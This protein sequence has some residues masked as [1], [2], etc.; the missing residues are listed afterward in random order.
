[1]D[2]TEENSSEKKKDDESNSPSNGKEDHWAEFIAFLVS[3]KYDFQTFVI[4]FRKA[5][6]HKNVIFF[7]S[8]QNKILRIND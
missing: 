1:M 5:K 8:N 6:V 3:E 2:V 4:F 7:I